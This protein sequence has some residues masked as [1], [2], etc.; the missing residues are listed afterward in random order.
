[1]SRAVKDE[2]SQEHSRVWLT[3]GALGG[4]VELREPGWA[5]ALETRP[6]PWVEAWLLWIPLRR[7]APPS[8]PG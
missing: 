8:L 4:R 1:M 2:S 6:G 7:K 3:E 5:A